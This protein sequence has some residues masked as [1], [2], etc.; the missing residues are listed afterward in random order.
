MINEFEEDFQQSGGSSQLNNVGGY[1]SRVRTE[2]ICSNLFDHPGIGLSHELHSLDIP[3][4]I[5]DIEEWLLD[6][7]RGLN[8]NG[9]DETLPNLQLPVTRGM[10]FPSEQILGSVNLSFAKILRSAVILSK[11]NKSHY[12]LSAP[13]IF[14]RS[15]LERKIEIVRINLDG[16]YEMD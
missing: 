5:G 9:W 6:I 14:T 1:S 15:R 8:W 16:Y 11:C 4:G 2:K 10:I 3:D 13:M 7:A 12:T